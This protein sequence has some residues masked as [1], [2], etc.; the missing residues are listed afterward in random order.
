MSLTT[1][2]SAFLRKKVSNS[3]TTAAISPS[4]Q[5]TLL[6]GL[7]SESWTVWNSMPF[8]TASSILASSSI[9]FDG[10]AVAKDGQH[11]AVATAANRFV[12]V[13]AAALGGPIH[14][15]Q[16]LSL[17]FSGG[18]PMISNDRGLGR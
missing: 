2:P 14:I 18:R 15:G 13:E 1:L 9:S 4:D 7:N 16:R 12:I 11:V 17:I 5:I 10:R 8:R 6:V 3:P